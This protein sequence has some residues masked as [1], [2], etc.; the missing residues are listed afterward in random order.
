[1]ASS[2]EETMT[3]EQ[4][5]IADFTQQH[6]AEWRLDKTGDCIYGGSLDL[7]HDD[8][9]LIHLTIRAD[10]RL[11]VRVFYGG[12]LIA[13][14]FRDG[15]LLTRIASRVVD[16]IQTYDGTVAALPVWLRDPVRS[17]LRARANKLL[18]AAR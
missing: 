2:T 8:G 3:N 13:G 16:A 12:G 5:Q 15:S 17:E 14:C 4:K 11:I 6:P 9:I 7:W 10:P 1:M 18:D